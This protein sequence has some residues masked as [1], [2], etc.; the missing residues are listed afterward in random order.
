MYMHAFN[1][2]IIVQILTNSVP[3]SDIENLRNCALFILVKVVMHLYVETVLL[4]VP[5]ETV[6]CKLLLSF[7]LYCLLY[8]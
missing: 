3:L 5:E 2:C 1:K 6:G 8:L 7:L 4:Y